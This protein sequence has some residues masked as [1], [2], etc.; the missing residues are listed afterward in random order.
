MPA[1]STASTPGPEAPRPAPRPTSSSWPGVT[2]DRTLIRKYDGPGP[3]YTSYPTAPNF[4]ELGPADYE[5]WLESSAQAGRQLSLYLH[6]PFCRTL[7]FYCGC[8]VTISHNPDRVRAYVGHVKREIAAVAERLAAGDREVVQFHLGGGTPNFVPPEDLR[9]LMSFFASSFRFHPAAEIGVEVDPRTMTPEHLDAFA[10][11]GV[12]RLSAG[13]QDLDPKVQEAIN[14]VQSADVTRA[15]VDGAHARGIE[16]VNLDLIY[17]LPHQTPETFAATVDQALAM[18]P[19][20]FAIFNFAYLP[21]MLRHQRVIDPASLPA[22]EEKLTILETAFAKLSEAGYV[23]IGMDHFARP[24]DPLSQALLDRS[25]TRNFQG[26]STW[27]ETDL[28]AFGA[29]GIGF[30]AD[31]YA[32]NVKTVAEYQER[33]GSGSLATCRGLELSA[34]DRLR[35]DVILAL[36]CHLHLDM[37]EVGERHGVDLADHFASELGALSPL[38]DDGLVELGPQT[39]DVT[40]VGRLLVRNVAMVFDEYL[41]A[42]R[43]VAFSRT[44]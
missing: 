7:C 21:K 8:N 35:R 25:L 23:M 41:A 26:Y 4:R 13:L 18:D 17:G 9:D 30:V 27:G 20:R 24:E 15:V 39:I 2:V 44:V 32:Q 40:P 38:A 10:E 37:G 34:E 5:R 28:V 36:M 14:R 31:A 19:E 22:A 12:N 3:R 1:V 16:S 29:S 33:I 42:N 6:L 43:Q 11:S